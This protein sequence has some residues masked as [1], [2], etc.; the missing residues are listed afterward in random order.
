MQSFISKVFLLVIGSLIV[1]ASC[2]EAIV[3]SKTPNMPPQ[4]SVFL[5]TVRTTQTTQMKLYWNGDDPDGTVIGFLYSLDSARTWNFTT[6]TSKQVTVPTL[7]YDSLI[8]KVLVAAVDNSGNGKYDE[9]VTY[10][11]KNIGH[12]FYIDKDKS[13]T[14]SSDETY[15]DYG[16]ID[17]SPA[18]FFVKV[19][20]GPPVSSFNLSAVIPATT[21][22]VAT[23]I[24]QVND[25]DGLDGIDKFEVALNDTL[26][27]G[28]TE[29][30]K[31]TSVLTLKGNLTDVVSDT[32]S[33]QVL[34]GFDAK[35]TTIYVPNMLVNKNNRLYFRVKDNTGAV[36]NISTMPA[37]GSPQNWFVTKPQSGG[38][39]LLIRDHF[40]HGF[41]D[42]D[43]IQAA[44]AQTPTSTPGVTYNKVD[45]LYLRNPAGAQIIP[46]AIQNTMVSVTL[47]SFKKA[48]WYGGDN[49]SYSLAQSV[50]PKY[51]SN[52]IKGKMFFRGGFASGQ[53]GRDLSIDF[54]PIDSLNS[55]YYYSDGTTDKT[56]NRGFRRTPNQLTL[57]R[58]QS[59]S[60]FP[61]AKPDTTTY[62][63]TL[64]DSLA[65]LQFVGSPLGT[66]YSFV[67]NQNAFVLYRLSLPRNNTKGVDL[68]WP[69][70]TAVYKGSG[71]PV[72]MI[73]NTNRNLVFTTVPFNYFS[74]VVPGY[75]K[76][77]NGKTF[78]TPLQELL[79]K[80]LSEEFER[81]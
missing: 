23:F 39:I 70:N 48:I 21:L 49:T 24:L 64:P 33:A 56:A 16:A 52:E 38:K 59:F 8:T 45:V 10:N 77:V 29:I 62:F 68:N 22:P 14:F 31:F 81:Q 12:E 53:T 67:P 51:L 63:K 44:L 61:T 43:L 20:N 13:G 75:P 42:Q 30:P 74:R 19:K 37:L 1:F 55:P 18:S 9:A 11:G 36:S 79:Y 60:A 2:K 66:Y 35:P 50:L 7:G 17:P 72:V 41:N 27:Y 5:D 54:L 40:S 73:E 65:S 4:T 26:K 78:A 25:P 76:N 15:Y 71:T 6:E 80:I 34:T 69:K 28:W 32:I 46:N 58:D 47:N 3:D 57:V